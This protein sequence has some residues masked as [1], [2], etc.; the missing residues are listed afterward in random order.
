MTGF[1]MVETLVA[2]GLFGAVAIIGLKQSE[3]M[4]NSSNELNLEREIIDFEA[5]IQ[6]LVNNTDA[7]E[8]SFKDKTVPFAITNLV[9]K[10]DNIAYSSTPPN[11]IYIDNKLKIISMKVTQ[12]LN[13]YFL[14]IEFEKTG[15][16]KS[17]KNFSKFVELMIE[18]DATNKVLNC[19]NIDNSMDETIQFLVAK[20]LCEKTYGADYVNYFDPVNKTCSFKGFDNNLNLQCNQ[21]EAMTGITYDQDTKTFTPI[22]SSPFSSLSCPDGWVKSLNSAGQFTCA[23]LSTYIDN[24]ETSMVLPTTCKLLSSAADTQIKLICASNT[25]APT[26][27]NQYKCTNSGFSSGGASCT[28]PPSG[29]SS[30]CDSGSTVN[31]GASVCCASTPSSTCTQSTSCT[32]RRCSYYRNTYGPVTEMGCTVVRGDCGENCSVVGTC[33]TS[34]P[35]N[36]CFMCNQGNGGACNPATECCHYQNGSLVFGPPCI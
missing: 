19:F 5:G 2:L 35:S 6:G 16:N 36:N 31:Q 10:N 9:D 13:N 28:P 15:D 26:L 4:G 3:M 18:V 21:G 17:M 1:S 20:N 24:S 27:G 29:T 25:P 34:N 11:N 33:D 22:C 14:D 32:P 7:C 30:L 23:T 8:K 12:K